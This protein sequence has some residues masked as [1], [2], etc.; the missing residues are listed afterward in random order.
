MGAGDITL[1]HIASYLSSVRDF[2]RPVVDQTGLSG[3]FDFS[4]NWA[5][6]PNPQDSSPMSR[7]SNADGPDLMEALR[8]RL[9]LKFQS[10]KSIPVRVLVFD[11]VERPS[12]HYYAVQ[13]L[14]RFSSA[15][16]ADSFLSISIY[17][18]CPR[19]VYALSSRVHEYQ[20]QVHRIPLRSHSRSHCWPLDYASYTQP[21][22]CRED[23]WLTECRTG[24]GSMPSEKLPR[25]VERVLTTSYLLGCGCVPVD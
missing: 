13:G 10:E 21:L 12:P 17:A 25:V 18:S 23:T 14:R 4:L 1:S 3:T 15:A 8:E 2:G 7:Q 11:H 6:S 9:G 19:I 5:R 22:P 20:Y 24:R 16:T